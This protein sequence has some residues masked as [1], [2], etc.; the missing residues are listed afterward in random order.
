LA[1]EATGVNN[2]FDE[3]LGIIL[4]SVVSGIVGYFILRA[5]YHDTAESK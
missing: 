4:G 3:R 2:V 1:F 5:C